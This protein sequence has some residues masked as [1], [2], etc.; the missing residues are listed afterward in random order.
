M[1]RSAA[2]K[3]AASLTSSLALAQQRLQPLQPPL[4][5]VVGDKAGGEAELLDDRV[6]R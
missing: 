4:G 5:V 6:E 2:I 3:G 1:P